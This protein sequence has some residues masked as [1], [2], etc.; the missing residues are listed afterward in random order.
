MLQCHTC[1]RT[2]HS[3]SG[4]SVPGVTFIYTATNCGQELWLKIMPSYPIGAI[5][6][7]NGDGVSWCEAMGGWGV[8][9]DMVMELYL[10]G[11]AIPMKSVLKSVLLNIKA[12]LNVKIFKCKA[13]KAI[14]VFLNIVLY[15]S[16]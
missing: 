7:R 2:L 16:E 1:I 15:F 9:M 12:L 5:T 10:Y 14:L 11:Y 13:S 8:H 3:Q 4:R 6:S